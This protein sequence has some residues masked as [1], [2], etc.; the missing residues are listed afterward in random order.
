M[1]EGHC[2]L[3]KRARKKGR[4]KRT[5]FSVKKKA[6]EIKMNDQMLNNRA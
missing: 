2:N 5:R 3:L 1:Y 4:E 6:T